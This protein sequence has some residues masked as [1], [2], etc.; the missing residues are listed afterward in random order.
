VAHY[1]EVWDQRVALLKF[2]SEQ[3]K[4]T[5]E[6]RTKIESHFTKVELDDLHHQFR[7]RKKTRATEAVEKGLEPLAE[8]FWNQE[9]DAWSVE[10]HIDVFVDPAKGIS[11]R[12]Q[13]LQGVVDIIAE[14]IWENADYR[15][16]LR[17]LL[18]NEGFVVST[19]VPKVGQKTKYNMYYERRRSV[20]TILRIASWP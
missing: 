15:R 3:G 16:A 11:T 18:W 4:L 10:E 12:E 17:E 1:R 9:P 19:V 6:L 20:S 13:A 8:Y 7:P 2:L 5:D 14:W